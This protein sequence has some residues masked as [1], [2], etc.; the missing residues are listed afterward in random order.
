MSEIS[1]QSYLLPVFLQMFN[2][3]YGGNESVKVPKISYN[4]EKFTFE[5]L[6]LDKI[7]NSSYKSTNPNS[8]NVRLRK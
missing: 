1:S 2:E 3:L 5:G 6:S 7:V 8:F 4:Y